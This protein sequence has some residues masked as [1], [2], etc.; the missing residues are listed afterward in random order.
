MGGVL[1]RYARGIEG[2][3]EY[4]SLEFLVSQIITPPNA[5]VRVLVQ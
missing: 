2:E 5:V 3:S 4:R 1:G